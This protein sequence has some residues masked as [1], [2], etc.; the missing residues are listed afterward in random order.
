MEMHVVLFKRSSHS[1]AAAYIN[2]TTPVCAVL[3]FNSKRSHRW[4]CNVFLNYHQRW[5]V[6]LIC[7]TNL[8]TTK[9]SI[10][11]TTSNAYVKGHLVR[12]LSS[13]YTQ[14]NTHQTNYI[15]DWTTQ[16]DR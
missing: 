10:W 5:P 15:T 16:N 1:M 9:N 11:T 8:V 4:A 14:T 6:A 12:T 7:E 13:A 2:E 3:E